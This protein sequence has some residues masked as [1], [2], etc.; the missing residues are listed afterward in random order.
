ML[1]PSISRW[2]FQRRRI[3][4]FT[5]SVWCF[6]MVCSATTK[7]LTTS[8]A[9]IHISASPRSAHS[10]EGTWP[11]SQ[12][13]TRPRMANSAASKIDMTA[14]STAIAAILPRTPCVQAH[15]KAKKPCGGNGGSAA[16]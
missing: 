9:A 5:A 13:T 2:K 7:M 15:R 16:G 8:T 14:V 12:S 6:T 11:P 3:G 1:W 4:R 10:R